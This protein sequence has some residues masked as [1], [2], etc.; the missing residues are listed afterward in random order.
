MPWDT[1]KLDLLASWTQ[2]PV[3]PSNPL[4]QIRT[5]SSSTLTNTLYYSN[6]NE[7]SALSWAPP[8]Y[9]SYLGPSS[10]KQLQN[11]FSAQ[12]SSK[13]P[14]AMPEKN[15]WQCLGYSCTETAVYHVYKYC[16]ISP[17]TISS[18]CAICCLL[19]HVQTE[20]LTAANA[21]FC[22]CTQLHQCSPKATVMQKINQVNEKIPPYLLPHPFV[23]NPWTNHTVIH[24]GRAWQEEEGGCPALSAQGGDVPHTNKVQKRWLLPSDAWRT[25]PKRTSWGWWACFICGRGHQREIQLQFKPLLPNGANSF[26][27]R[28]QTGQG[29][30]ATKCSLGNSY[31]WSGWSPGTNSAGTAAQ[32]GCEVSFPEH[33]Q[34]SAKLF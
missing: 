30:R 27:W 29:A 17:H 8:R 10:C 9:L 12:L 33:F 28:Q 11:H 14:P 31:S 16:L 19:W 22:A 34:G 24:M 13:T 5:L 2:P 3:I 4:I 18:A 6:L 20:L 1:P 32:R 21:F 7:I 25:G 23:G 26:P 15:P